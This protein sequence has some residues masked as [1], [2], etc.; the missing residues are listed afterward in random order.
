MIGSEYFKERFIQIS[1]AEE[2]EIYR[3][4]MDGLYREMGDV[5][6]DVLKNAQIKGNKD[7]YYGGYM[8]E[9]RLIGRV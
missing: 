8:Y 7:V 4:Y 3:W 9:L 1:P 5:F 6:E 2:E